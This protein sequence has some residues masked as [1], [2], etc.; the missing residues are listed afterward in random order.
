VRKAHRVSEKAFEMMVFMVLLSGIL[1]FA[2]N[3]QMVAATDTIYVRADGSFYLPT[4]P[5]PNVGNVSCT[6]TSNINDSIVVERDS[7]LIDGSLVPL[8]KDPSV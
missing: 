7:V 1:T 3:V 5:I 4:A 2:F 6:F 8:N